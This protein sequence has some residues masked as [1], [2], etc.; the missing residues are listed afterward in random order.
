[1][2]TAPREP[3]PPPTEPAEL[4][5]EAV[6]AWREQPGR[7]LA[8][9]RELEGH[10]TACLVA[11]DEVFV[12]VLPDLWR[13]GW[14]PLDLLHVLSRQ[15][16]ARHVAVAA[17]QVLVGHREG[18]GGD[19]QL[20]PRWR[21]QLAGLEERR[22]VTGEVAPAE[23]LRLALEVL[24]L[25]VRLPEV[26]R[27]I[28]VPGERWSA[29]SSASHLDARV[30]DRVRALL[31]KAESTTFEAEAEAFTAKA[32]ELIARHAI[33]EA[34]LHD[35]RDV[36]E[37]AARRVL[38]DDPYASAKAYLV[39]V[40][41]DANHCRSVQTPALGWVTVFGYDHDLDAVELLA[42]SLL[43]QATAGMVRAGPKRDLDGRS[44]TRSFR[45]A[46][47]IGF[48]E[49][50]GERLRRATQEQ[51]S[52]TAESDQ[53][54]LPVLAARDE[55]VRAAQQAAFP[56]LVQREVSLSNTEGWH[57]GRAAA[58]LADLGTPARGLR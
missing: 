53:R 33:D 25:V 34:L 58:E 20:H 57:A 48:A 49:R 56:A 19:H 26:T 38:V 3:H 50:V 11:V 5:R 39:Q 52:V 44:V 28:P 18:H 13:R 46:F 29:G 14:T 32:Q 1:V 30:L 31:A 40:V 36:G 6:A 54:L 4:V 51:V 21:E 7:F 55:R 8:I 23:R 47:L 27:T 17:E 10:E 22:R 16:S 37:P 45:R 35:V 15:L 41:A 24:A 2:V 12:S 43:T 42:A 9:L